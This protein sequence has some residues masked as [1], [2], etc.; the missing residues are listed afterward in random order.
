[1]ALSFSPPQHTQDFQPAFLDNEHFLVIAIETAIKLDWR[2]SFVSK[3]SL[4]AYTKFSKSSWS[5]KVTIKIENGNATLQSKCTEWQL[6]DL[7]KNKKNIE[8]FLYKF[9]E[10]RSAMTPKKME[11]KL[12]ELKQKYLAAGYAKEST[13]PLTAKEKIMGLLSL[14][15]P[16][17][18]HFVTTILLYIN[19][20]IFI[21]MAVTGVNVLS[22][23]NESLLNWGANFKPVTLDGQWW[24]L[25]TN[26]FI[27]IG[28]AHLVM[29]M[30]ALLYIGLLLEPYFGK[31]R[32][33]AA[34]LLT[35][36]SASV[37]SLW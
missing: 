37:T 32:F 10:V 35:G 31:T 9:K 13:P 3:S 1:M 15:T 14:L 19:I 4:I 28:L 20:L 25:L 12:T 21:A 33:I 16:T 2:I 30:Y 17:E 27:H 18:D 24:R 8:S 11:W 7:G 34:Y 26:C 22:P 29:N 23:D 36:I 6:H 5:E